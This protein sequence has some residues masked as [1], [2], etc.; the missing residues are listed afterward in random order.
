MR[1]QPTPLA[2]QGRGDLGGDRAVGGPGGED[3]DVADRRRQLAD[4]GAAG[5]GVDAASGQRSRT[6][7]AVA[8]STRVA[9]AGDG[10]AVEQ[11]GE[12]GD[13]LRGVFPAA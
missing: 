4:E 12:A 6:A 1:V 5:L 3:D 13:G 7:A 8:S 2:R 9:Q 11:G 10:A